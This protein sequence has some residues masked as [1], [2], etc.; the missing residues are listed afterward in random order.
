VQTSLAA[1]GALVSGTPSGISFPV[2]D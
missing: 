1:S 2:A